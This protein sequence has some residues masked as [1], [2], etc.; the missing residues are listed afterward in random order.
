[1][2]CLFNFFMLLLFASQLVSPS[3]PQHHAGNKKADYPEDVKLIPME[4]P[5]SRLL[6][7]SRIIIHHGKETAF[8]MA[9]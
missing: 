9:R 4:C 5:G 2:F 8:E 6:M 7:C 1:M 3:D